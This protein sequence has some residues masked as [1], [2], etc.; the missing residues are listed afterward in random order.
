MV[1]LLIV[2]KCCTMFLM[3]GG[4]ILREQKA[5]FGNLLIQTSIQ[6]IAK[7]EKLEF[8][9]LSLDLAYSNE[10]GDYKDLRS[11][12][13]GNEYYSVIENTKIFSAGL[14]TELAGGQNDFKWA[15]RLGYG[16][17]FGNFHLYKDGIKNLYDTSFINFS[18]Y[19]NIKD[20]FVVIDA[21]TYSARVGLGYSF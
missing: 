15:I 12:F 10:F 16:K 9:F 5:G 6:A 11:R 17:N 21:S 13:K 7:T 19:G 8:R 4:N 20:A 1:L 3:R 14:N 18:L 2:E